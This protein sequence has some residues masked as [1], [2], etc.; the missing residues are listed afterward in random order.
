MQDTIFVE[1]SGGFKIL[2]HLKLIQQ[3]A[4]C[5][6]SMRGNGI[7]EKTNKCHQCDFASSQ[8]GT[9]K[10]HL[11]THTGEKSNKCNQ[12]DYASSQPSNLKIH[13]KTNNG[14]KPNK[15]NSNLTILC[16]GRPLEDTFEKAQ[17]AKVKKC[18]LRWI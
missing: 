16:F 3:K 4:D 9:L 8:S 7:G 17:S 2:D 12:C 14:E 18:H 11:K 1:C 5:T 6:V 13:F 15:C 10:R